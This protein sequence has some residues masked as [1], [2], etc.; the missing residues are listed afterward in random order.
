MSLIKLLKNNRIIKFPF[1]HLADLRADATFLFYWL[2]EVSF[3]ERILALNNSK[4]D[5]VAY[6]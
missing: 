4:V 6:H 5:V 1:N 2:K 3:V